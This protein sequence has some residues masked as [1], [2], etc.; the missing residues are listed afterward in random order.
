MRRWTIRILIGLAL[1]ILAIVVIVQLVLWSTLPNK[2]VMAQIEKQLGLRISANTLRTTWFGHT[3]LTG[4]SLGLP[5]NKQSFLSVKTMQIK[6]NSLLG[7][8]AGNAIAVDS[9]EIDEPKVEVRQNSAGQWNLA[10]VAQLLVRALGSKTATKSASTDVP[11]LPRI[12]VVNATVTLTNDQG[13]TATLDDVNVNGEPENSLVWTYE[14][15]VG[16]S[17]HLVGKVAPGGNWKHE[18]SL[19][20][21]HLQPLVQHYGLKTYGAMVNAQWTGE[22]DGSNIKGRLDLLQASANVPGAGKILAKGAVDVSTAGTV[23]T[24]QPQK[25]ELTTGNAMLS[26]VRVAS[27]KIVYDTSTGI[28]LHSI[29]LG[30]LGGLAVVDGKFDPALLTGNFAAR[31]NGLGLPG[32]LKHNGSF[33]AD[34]KMPFTGKPIIH[35]DLQSHGQK[36]ANRWDANLKLAGVGQS[37]SDIKWVLTA[38]QL[39]Y[40][41][42][43]TIDLSDL[44]G[45]ITQQLPLIRLDDLKLPA[46]PHL[47]SYGQYQLDTKAWNFY[48]DAGGTA[49][50]A[51]QPLPINFSIKAGGDKKAITL[52]SF[53]AQVAQLAAE[54]HGSYKFREPNPINLDVLL[55]ESSPLKPPSVAAAVQGHIH[56][57]FL[58]TGALYKQPNKSF[59]PSIDM[60]GKLISTDLVV[61]HKPVG[62]INIQVTGGYHNKHA[63][64]QTTQL[65][66][67]QGKWKFVADYPSPAKAV[68]AELDADQLPLDVLTNF[69]NVKGVSGQLTHAQW[70]INANPANLAKLHVDSTYA[71]SNIADESIPNLVINHVNA[72]GTVNDGDISLKP[73][74]I[75]SGTGKIDG[76]ITTTLADYN[77]VQAE[78]HV[79]QFPFSAGGATA[80]TTADTKLVIDLKTKTITGPL[81]ATTNVVYNGVRLMHAVLDSALRDRTLTV[82]SLAGNVLNGTFQGH[83][84]FDLD[85]P[86]TAHGQFRWYNIDSAALVAVNPLLTGVGGKYSGTVT[87]GPASQPKPLEPVRIDVN[88]SAQNGHYKT[89]E[90]GQHGLFAVHAVAYVGVGRFVLDHSDIDVAN[91]TAHLWARIDRGQDI[92]LS[93]DKLQLNQLAHVVNSIKGPYP[94]IIGGQISV[95]ASGADLNTING[96]ALVNITQSDLANFAPLALMYNTLNLGANPKPI[97]YGKVVM[98]FE[99][100]TL[101]VDQFNYFNRGIDAIGR[102]KVGPLV[103]PV[104]S[105]PVT[106]LVVGTAQVLKNSRVQILSDF[107]DLFASAQGNLTTIAVDGT[108][109]HIHPF[110]E[111][112]AQV[113][114][115]FN[116]IL[117]GDTANET[118]VPNGK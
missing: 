2:I 97:G 3:T 115:Q 76:S 4:V 55:N 38:P 111:A 94:G 98:S 88:V 10:E 51:N 24:L 25:L 87:I 75:T 52:K 14:L 105:T 40:Q 114:S 69:V 73:I 39:R 83:S 32:G 78:F 91:G 58:I 29:D 112:A 81:T 65:S 8:A 18:I 48:M 5:L 45:H 104:N 100:K 79:H 56:G 26:N 50:A 106:G 7:L 72:V 109:G 63:H 12:K 34:L 54:A 36:G 116:E 31:W 103:M 118:G 86:L 27:G 42:S 90:I 49:S 15:S 66:L 70:K 44:S 41:G 99:K 74:N 71:L 35:V 13:K 67:L 22:L 47:L 17:I 19:T 33:T 68:T 46:R 59:D 37:W 85:K 30:A 20:A 117:T 110:A 61:L 9:I 77:R 84:K 80:K 43:K 101:K 64:L 28:T 6:A 62:D 21:E 1:L 102:F 113:A 23:V 107:N 96:Q 95:V 93:F 108:I 92:I 16:H 89:V 57:S 60:H 53:K 11:K 82:K